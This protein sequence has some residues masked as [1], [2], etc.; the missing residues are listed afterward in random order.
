MLSSVA[1]KKQALRLKLAELDVVES[2]MRKN[3]EKALLEPDFDPFAAAP[4]SGVLPELAPQT[5]PPPNIQ[6]LSN[7][8]PSLALPALHPRQISE[9]RLDN[10][11]LDTLASESADFDNFVFA[12]TAAQDEPQQRTYSFPTMAT[13]PPQSEESIPYFTCGVIPGGIIPENGVVSPLYDVR[14]PRSMSASTTASTGTQRTS[15]RY[16]GIDFRTGLSGH[17]GLTSASAHVDRL[18]VHQRR[19]IRMMGEHR[20]ISSVRRIRQQ[21]SS[22]SPRGGLERQHPSW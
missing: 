16:Q 4:I 19:E 18:Q 2:E 17:M 22:G 12:V 20:G 5:S 11:G 13:L 15:P 9:P 10:L 8:S 6:D 3:L 1:S 21:N 7:A 14:R